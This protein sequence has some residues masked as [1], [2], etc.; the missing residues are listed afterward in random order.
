[1]LINSGSSWL[2]LAPNGQLCVPQNAGVCDAYGSNV[3]ATV[4]GSTATLPP[5]GAADVGGYHVVTGAL[6]PPKP[7]CADY[8]GPPFQAAAVKLP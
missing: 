5:Y 8:F 4:N 1:M 6:V 7:S 3:V 2:T